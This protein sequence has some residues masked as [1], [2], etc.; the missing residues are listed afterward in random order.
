MTDQFEL[1]TTDAHLKASKLLF[2]D[3]GYAPVAPNR[4]FLM[5]HAIRVSHADLVRLI[6]DGTIEVE[7]SDS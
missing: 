3:E 2:G 7:E 6:S 1:Q 4:K 5:I